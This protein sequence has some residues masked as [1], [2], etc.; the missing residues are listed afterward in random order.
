MARRRKSADTTLRNAL[1]FLLLVLVGWILD[2]CGLFGRGAQAAT[3]AA[4]RPLRVGAWNIEWCGRPQDRSGPAQGV[5]QDPEDLADYVAFAK[6]AV[7]AVEEVIADQPGERSHILDRVVAA[8]DTRTRGRWAYVLNPGRRDDDQRTGVLWDGAQ[9]TPR[10]PGGQDWDARQHRPWRVP[11]QDRKTLWAR[12]PHAMC[13]SAGPERTDFVV[14]PLHMKADYLGDFARQREGEARA[15]V[16]AL[17]RI[18]RA[19]TDQDVLLIGDANLAQKVEP[20]VSVFET[21]G[22]HWLNAERR[23]THWP[24]GALD[25][26]FVPRSQPEFAGDFEV[27]AEQYFLARG[28]SAAEFRRRYSDHWLVVT[29]VRVM[30]DDD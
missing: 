16:T 7:L 3:G 14:V 2:E 1:V 25:A 27:V 10:T 22:W 17:P 9:V 24:S 30:A 8:L 21:A 12:P 5:R 29:S 20:A 28:L 4:P 11:I 15:L 19:F 18:E 13:F 23:P 26:A 6:V